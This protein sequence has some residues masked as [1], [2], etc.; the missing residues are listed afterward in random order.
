MTANAGPAPFVVLK[1][2]TGQ[3]QSGTAGAPKIYD[4]YTIPSGS[5]QGD[6][7]VHNVILR[8]CVLASGTVFAGN[9]V[10]VDHCTIH[11][12]VSLSGGDRFVFTNNN[13]TGWDDAVH[14]TSDS[15]PVKIVSVTGNWLHSPSPACA[16]HSDGVQLLGVEN[17]TFRYNVIDLGPWIHCSATNPDEGPL[18]GAFQVETT[19][20]PV[21]NVTIDN[22]WLNGGGYVLRVYS[23][24]T[25][26]KITNNQF[27][28]DARW[29]PFDTADAGSG[30]T[31]FSGN[32][33]EDNGQTIA[34]DQ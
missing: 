3:L 14:I 4:G 1:P 6:L 15:G 25:N 17:A 2:L 32:K 7:S 10:T 28:R 33:Y 27:G 19:Q 29:G 12:G 5:L 24:C 30:V 22:N 8:N 18:N 21:N 16:D 26:I 20:G 9:D 11:G 23:G 34:R 13:V 31:T